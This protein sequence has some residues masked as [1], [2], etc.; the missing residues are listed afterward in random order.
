M[1]RIVIGTLACLLFG[2][3]VHTMHAQ[4]QKFAVTLYGNILIPLGEFGEK[5]GVSPRLTQRSGFDYGERVGLATTGFGGGV[6]VSTLVHGEHLSWIVSGK[7]LSSPTDD[8]KIYP[9]FKHDFG[10][11]LRVTFNNGNWTNIPILTGFK[12]D[13]DISQSI[14]LYGTVQGGVNITQQ[15]SRKAFVDGVTVEETSFKFMADFGFEAGI[16][17]ELFKR[18]NVGARYVNLGTPRYEGTRK[19]NVSYFPTVPR[20]E[21]SIDGD[22]RPVSMLLLIIG[23]E[24]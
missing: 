11:S 14:S 23:Y 19:L 17:I 8:S 1:K 5:I 13:Y 15:A 22:E 16:G 12:Y 24:L 7:F 18:F 4:D 2:L 9:E 10:D 3:S 6:E 21:M 20:R